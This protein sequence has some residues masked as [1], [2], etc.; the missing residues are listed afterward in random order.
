M[1]LLIADDH[2]LFRDALL[3]Y[4][5]RSNPDAIVE[6][7][8]DFYH[9]QDILEEDA[10]FDLVILDLRMPGM[11]GLEG[12]RT[13][14]KD[15]PDMQ[16]ALMSGVASDEDVQAAL[17]LGISGYFPKTLSGKALIRAI[18]AVLE[19]EVFVPFERD[20]H[21][22]RPAYYDDGYYGQRLMTGVSGVAQS[23]LSRDD[24]SLTPREQDVLFYL[25]TGASN[26]DIASALELQVV[27][28]KLHVRGI[29]RK[30]GAKNR[31]QAALI[32]VE[33]RIVLKPPAEARA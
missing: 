16:V 19:G 8:R 14:R 22:I 3:Q 30:L 6:L 10:D 4:I 20:P 27:T 23:G 13:L 15:Y 29:C 7:A 5:A 31:T 33:N 9:T 26:K 24:F 32:A 12:V 2:T 11:K 25:V 1:K 28:V 21:Q 17:D 18:E